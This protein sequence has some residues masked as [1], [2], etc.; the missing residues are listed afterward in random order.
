MSRYR[1]LRILKCDPLSAG[2]IAFFNWL[3][4]VPAGEIRVFTAC[5]TYDHLEQP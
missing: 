5:L 2:I 4:D 3:R 1:A